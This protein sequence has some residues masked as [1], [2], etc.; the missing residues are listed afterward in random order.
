M[1]CNVGNFETVDDDSTWAANR[2]R[3]S[4]AVAGV[5]VVVPT[6]DLADEAM[7][8]LIKV[9]ERATVVAADVATDVVFVD[10]DAAV[11]VVVVVDLSLG[12]GMEEEDV[13]NERDGGC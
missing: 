10:P 7:V 12:V 11:V 9:D 5:V 6:L 1:E 8:G 2:R 4:A 3:N 13:R